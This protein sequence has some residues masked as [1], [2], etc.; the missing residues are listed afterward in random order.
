[1][2]VLFALGS[3]LILL[4]LYLV[5]WAGCGGGGF[6]PASC[7]LQ[8][9]VTPGFNPGEGPAGDWV[10]G[11]RGVSPHLSASGSLS[12]RAVSLPRT[13]ALRGPAPRSSSHQVTL[14]LGFSPGKL[15]PPATSDHLTSLLG[16]STFPSAVSPPHCIYTS[17]VLMLRVDL[18]FLV[19]PRLIQLPMPLP[20]LVKEPPTPWAGVELSGRHLRPVG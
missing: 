1:M 14:A 9:L 15:G 3:L 16:F 6:S 8:A 12:S 19:R 4:L 10:A 2:L 17:S 11:E 7:V 5:S 20:L 13:S 18:M